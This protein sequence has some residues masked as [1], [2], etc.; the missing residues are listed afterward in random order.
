VEKFLPGQVPIDSFGKGGFR[1]GDM[2]HQGSLLA[3]P[4]GM[5]A[6]P[7]LEIADLSIDSLDKV[8]SERVRIDLLLIGTGRDMAR[9]PADTLKRLISAGFNVEFMSTSSALHTYNVVLA[10]G[11]RVAAA[12]IAV[13]ERD[14]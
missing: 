7:V 12:L 11:R 14:G 9:L 10:E 5:H 3:L 13:D 6:W 1:F 2:S 4:S 8:L